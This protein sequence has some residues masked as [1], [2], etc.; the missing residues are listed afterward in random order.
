MGTYSITVTSELDKLETVSRFVADAAGRMGMGDDE[1]YAIQ[2]A[3]DEACTNVMDYAYQGKSGQ[4]VTVEC[5]D[6]DG[7]CVVTVRDH[8]R[9]FDPSRV[10]MPDLSAPLSRRQI[11]GLGI[12]L[13]RKLMDDVRFRFDNKN[14]NE[15]TLVKSI[16]THRS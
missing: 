5:C 16:K 9:P 8:G 11:G 15:L 6:D 2:L 13:I 10:V 7:K 12:Y 4:P 1:I 14:G 3:V